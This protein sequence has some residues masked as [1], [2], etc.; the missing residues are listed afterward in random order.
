MVITG[1]PPCYYH[2]ILFRRGSGFGEGETRWIICLWSEAFRSRRN[3]TA[4]FHLFFHL[5]FSEKFR[6]FAPGFFCLK[7][8]FDSGAYAMAWYAFLCDSVETGKL[9]RLIERAFVPWENASNSTGCT[10]N[11]RNRFQVLG[12]KTM[13]A[14]G[15]VFSRAL[16]CVLTSM[17]FQT[18]DPSGTSWKKGKSK[19]SGTKTKR[20]KQNKT[21]KDEDGSRT[22]LVF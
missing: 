19:Q 20:K 14:K 15:Q 13:S 3:S 17:D 7:N 18:E 5:I 4:I 10:E 8:F 2:D 16:A 9:R 11:M 22:V 1:H 6:R 12:K 21:Q